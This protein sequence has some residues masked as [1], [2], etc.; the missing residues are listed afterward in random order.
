MVEISKV[1]SVNPRKAEISNLNGSTTVSFVP[2]S[3]LGENEMYFKAKDQK[4]LQDVGPSYTYFKESDVLV[5]KVTPCFENGKAGI[6]KDLINGIGFG[7]SEFYVLRPGEF[8]TTQ[9]IYF[10]IAT[11]EFRS[12]ATPK[13]TGTGGLQR[14]PRSVIESYHIP[15]PSITTQRTILTEIEAERSIVSA[16]EDLIQRLQSKTEAVIDQVW[17]KR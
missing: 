2:M 13:M 1:C 11:P 17:G 16:N 15:L 12:W 8:V 10:S 5:A 4:R 7:S 3:D 9:W 14:V 6:A